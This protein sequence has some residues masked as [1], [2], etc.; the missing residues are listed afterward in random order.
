MFT[1]RH[2]SKGRR[3][4]SRGHAVSSGSF[5]FQLRSG[6]SW[7]GVLLWSSHLIQNRTLM[8]NWYKD[9]AATRCHPCCLSQHTCVP[10]DASDNLRDLSVVISESLSHTV[11]AAVDSA[12]LSFSGREGAAEEQDQGR[13]TKLSNR[14]I[15]HVLARTSL[16]VPAVIIVAIFLL[17]P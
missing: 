17:S 3:H 16:S 1:L 13:R 11:G 10:R 5:I 2:P 15:F 14:S 6:G 7:C 12:V 9:V 4:W 8:K